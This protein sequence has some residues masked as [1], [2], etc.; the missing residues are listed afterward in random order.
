MVSSHGISQLPH[1]E[2]VCLTNG[3]SDRQEV[4]MF[5]QIVKYNSNP[6]GVIS[7]ANSEYIMALRGEHGFGWH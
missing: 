4:Q 5:P 6:I 1:G 2:S 3:Q 7:V